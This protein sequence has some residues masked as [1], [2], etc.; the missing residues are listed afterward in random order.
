MNATATVG[1]TAR[2]PRVGPYGRP[3]RRSKARRA[4]HLAHAFARRA[5]LARRNGVDPDLIATS[6]RS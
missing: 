5:R 3:T 4:R 2:P 6:R 1:H